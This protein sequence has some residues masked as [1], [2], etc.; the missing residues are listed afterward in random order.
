MNS[1]QSPENSVVI[2]L[3]A[4]RDA[5]AARADQLF[6]IYK[7]G[8]MAAPFNK[9][10][11]ERF[12]VEHSKLLQRF[13]EL[14]R[15]PVQI[16][17][18][19]VRVSR[20]IID[21]HQLA[22]C[23]NALAPE[24]IKG[25][26]PQLMLANN[27]PPS[28]LDNPSFDDALKGGAYQVGQFAEENFVCRPYF[29]RGRITGTAAPGGVGKSAIALYEAMSIVCGSDPYS[30]LPI[31]PVR[32]VYWN[33]EDTRDASV[34]RVT[35]M[36]KAYPDRFDPET[37]Q[38]NLILIGAELGGLK[39][40]IT[41]GRTVQITEDI[42]TKLIERLWAADIGLV[43]LDPL[44]AL[45]SVEENDNGA[46]ERLMKDA[47]ARVARD[48]NCAIHIVHHSGKGANNSGD[49]L[50]MYR[51]ASSVPAALR[52]ARAI[53]KATDR[54]LQEVGIPEIEG[55]DVLEIKVAKNNI[56]PG[57]ECY[58]RY[59]RAKSVVLKGTGEL[60]PN[61]V[62]ELAIHY[63]RPTPLT[64]FLL[65]NA[66]HIILEIAK[67]SELVAAGKKSQHWIG[68]AILDAAGI[69]YG[70][71]SR[72]QAINVPKVYTDKI[73]RL[74]ADAV[75]QR[76]VKIEKKR[77]RNGNQAPMYLPVIPP[78]DDGETLSDKVVPDQLP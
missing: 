66:N 41:E 9:P 51:G 58:P 34:R 65:E 74:L 15:R 73:E 53:Y 13:R 23:F 54:R 30:D 71:N 50:D 46:M 38:R 64:E 36:C 27:L 3:Q 62:T 28:P 33:L 18:Q 31:S 5:A 11:T 2:D 78:S 24:Q 7:S 26:R 52:M 35:A 40:A 14:E 29:A 12:V 21:E 19:A 47:L 60:D 56:V 59:V 25:Q 4:H 1:K 63:V 76:V 61:R 77:D 70:E 44:V 22:E 45:H 42:V 68:K 48:A 72:G 49:P 57:K 37:L 16:V 39:L 6:E 32:C 8:R 10:N 67:T 55:M 20:I 69:T 17:T 75:E 43:V